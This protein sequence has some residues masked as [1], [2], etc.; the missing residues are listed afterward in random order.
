MGIARSESSS[1]GGLPASGGLLHAE[2]RSIRWRRFGQPWTQ[3][4]GASEV[5]RSRLLSRPGGAI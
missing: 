2:S 4:A 1:R 3:P 5:E